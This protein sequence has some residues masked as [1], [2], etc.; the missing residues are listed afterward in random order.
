[1]I[2]KKIRLEQKSNESFFEGISNEIA[3][4]I[5]R[6]IGTVEEHEEIVS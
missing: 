1:M 6:I 5:V 2:T 4:T 3:H